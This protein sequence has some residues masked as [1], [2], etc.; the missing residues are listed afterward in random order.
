MRIEKVKFKS[1]VTIGR[2]T[3]VELLSSECESM[4]F[5]GNVLRIDVDGMSPTK[6]IPHGTIHEMDEA[7]KYEECPECGETFVNAK[8]LGGHRRHKH[9][10]KGKGGEDQ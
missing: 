8:G 1:H 6:L 9:G 10:V 5:D 3:T 4:E 7:K 2:R